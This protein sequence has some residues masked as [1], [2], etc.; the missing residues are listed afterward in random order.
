MAGNTKK[1]W[2][3][4]DGVMLRDALFDE[5][6]QIYRDTKYRRT[7]DLCHLRLYGNSQYR[8]LGYADYGRTSYGPRGNRVTLNIVGSIVDTIVAK[9][10]KN[11]PKATFQTVN[12]DESMQRR[13][14]RLDKFAMGAF[15]EA[16]FYK[17]MAKVILDAAVFGTGFLKTFVTEEKNEKGE[18]YP[19]MCSER[20]LPMEIL[21]SDTDAVYE[22][23]QQIFQ[24]RMYDRDVLIANYPEKATA[25]RQ[26]APGSTLEANS[27]NAG[28][29]RFDDPLDP[30][31]ERMICVLEGWRLPAGDEP[32]RHVIA[33][34]NEILLDE[35]YTSKELPF[36]VL[37]WRSKL[38]GFWGSGI[39]A[40]IMGLQ[41]EIN[42]LLIQIQIQMNLATPKVLMEAGSKISKAQLNNE[43]WGIIE[44][45]G[46]APIFYVPKTVSGEIFAHIDRLYQRS[47]EDVGLSQLSAS[48]VK[49]A[50][51]ESGRALREMYNIETER[52]LEFGSQYEDAS[53][54][55]AKRFVKMAH[56]LYVYDGI[57]REVIAQDDDDVEKI[58]WSEIDLDASDYTM[59]LYPS[60]L[61][62]QTPAGRFAAVQEMFA[63][64]L[65][66]REMAMRLLKFPDLES[67]LS[68]LNAPLD[69]ALYLIEEMVGK[70]RYHAPEPFSNLALNIQ[71]LTSAYL[72]GQ[73]NGVP[74]ERLDLLRQYVEEARMLLTSSQSSAQMMLGGAGVPSD[75]QQLNGIVGGQ[76]GGTPE[77]APN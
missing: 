3:R 9:M 37:R 67:A 68:L 31:K 4:E 12:G 49:P 41:C 13:A 25:L 75:A 24:T 77:V 54:E 72:R 74:E 65:L 26:T 61:L 71:V 63:T 43:T 50:G 56:D 45:V 76:G 19:K 57:D 1:S 5:A 35:E 58:K 11:K 60:N 14:Q 47:F 36:I 40:Q 46:N 42:K 18:W 6:R 39:A 22:D 23:P 7:D 69:N 66:S 55:A 48:G 2:W 27:P 32:G 21:V 28:G 52:F 73:S 16:N 17:N 10:I 44:Y 70:G 38:L 64:G 20:V 30:S 29:S 53:I 34:E 33:V 51:L 59:K 62:P 8:G 15:Y